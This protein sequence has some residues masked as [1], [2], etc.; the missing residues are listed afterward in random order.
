MAVVAQNILRLSLGKVPVAKV[1]LPYVSGILLAQYLAVEFLGGAWVWTMLFFLVLISIGLNFYSRG[2]KV[3]KILQ[4]LS[5]FLFWG[6]L[7]YWSVIKTNPVY[8]QNYFLSMEAGQYTGQI[9]DEP[10]FREKSIRFPLRIKSAQTADSS[11]RVTGTIMVTLAREEKDSVQNP[12]Q[13]GDVIAIKNTIKAVPPPYNPYE[14][15][16]RTY[17]ANKDIGY[18]CYL[19]SDQYKLV[20]TGE[21]NFL[22]SWS[23]QFRQRLIEKFETYQQDK[24][25][26]QVAI[27]LIFGYRSQIDAATLRAFTN[28]GTIHVLSVSGLHVGLVFGFLTLLLGWMDRFRYGKV[29]RCTVILLS[30]WSYVILT[31]MAPPILRAGIMIS[32]FLLSLMV[33]RKQI[34]LNTLAAS[35]F[36]ILLFSPKALFDVGFQLSYMAMLGIL[37]LYPLLCTLYLPNNKYLAWVVEY[38]YVS[39]AAQLFTLP[40]VLYYF[41]QFPNYFLLANLFIALPSTGIM[42]VGLLLA[43]CPIAVLSAFFAKVLDFLLVFL[44]EGLG[45]IERLPFATVRGIDWPVP[46][47]LGGLVFVLATVVAL[48]SRSKRAVLLGGCMIVGMVSITGYT[49]V[50]KSRYSGMKIYNMRSAFALAHIDRGKVLLYSSYD[51]LMHPNLQFSVLPDLMRYSDVDKIEFVRIGGEGRQ[52]SII[53]IGEYRVALVEDRWRAEGSDSVD[54]VVWRKNNRATLD[55]IRKNLKAGGMVILDGSNSDKYVSDFEKKVNAK[56]FRVYGL[57]DNFAYVWDR[58]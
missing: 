49:S 27:A 50:H 35:A 7:G 57:K 18:Q 40:F 54:I 29:L 46:L 45:W 36:F 4:A 23:L 53:H 37:L 6:L 21:G 22:V 43:C 14:F 31:G 42:Y 32:F 30:V 20:S 44:L 10:V 12:L 25:A 48:N 41:G 52:N 2:R 3:W 11:F 26:F 15:D 34:P 38:C 9:I 51:S 1:L 33:R 17:L 56:T 13:Y 8:Q 58:D 19:S 24:R 47:L 5:I 55:S 39:V 16:Y 28:T